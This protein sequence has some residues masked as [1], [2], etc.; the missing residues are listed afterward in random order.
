MWNLP[1][2]QR[3]GQAAR[4]RLTKKETHTH[5]TNGRKEQ[6][7]TA[8]ETV[9]ASQPRR[10]PPSRGT[11]HPVTPEVQGCVLHTRPPPARRPRRRHSRRPLPAG[12]KSCAR[13]SRPL[14]EGDADECLTTGRREVL[15]AGG[16]RG[17]QN[18]VCSCV[19]SLSGHTLRL[20]P[21]PETP[22]DPAGTEGPASHP[23]RPW[24]SRSFCRP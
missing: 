4:L 20:Q 22:S 10:L 19:R 3:G 13:G 18:R 7:G 12:T 11:S 9:P 23:G 8:R 2:F 17:F 24:G 6:A 5:C 16:E 1:P 14:P 15:R 21:G